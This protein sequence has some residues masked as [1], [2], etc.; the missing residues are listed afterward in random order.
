MIFTRAGLYFGRPQEV[1]T[2]DDVSGRKVRKPFHT[3]QHEIHNGFRDIHECNFSIMLKE[4]ETVNELIGSKR[5]KTYFIWIWAAQRRWT[6][7][8][9]LDKGKVKSK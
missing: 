1:R 3:P 6:V 9:F 5:L 8:P 2:E 4:R 7:H